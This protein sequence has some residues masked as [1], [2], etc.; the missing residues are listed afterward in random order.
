LGVWGSRGTNSNGTLGVSRRLIVEGR[1]AARGPS[2][3]L[4]RVFGCFKGKK[5]RMGLYLGFLGCVRF[6]VRTI[7]GTNVLGVYGLGAK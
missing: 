2:F 6:C 4:G 1:G 7:N 3:L 5:G